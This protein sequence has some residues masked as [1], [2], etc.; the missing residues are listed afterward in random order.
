MEKIYR[1]KDVKIVK[2]LMNIFPVTAILGH[3]K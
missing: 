1:A 3:V 2:E